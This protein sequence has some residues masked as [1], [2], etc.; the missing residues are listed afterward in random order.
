MDSCVNVGLVNIPIHRILGT[1][2]AGRVTAFTP[3]FRPLLES[4]TEFAAKWISLC[5]AHLGDTG[6]TDPIQCFEY[7]GNFYVQ[8]GL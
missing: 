7:L 8:E 3:T 6:I 5:K 1:K 4:D 2:T